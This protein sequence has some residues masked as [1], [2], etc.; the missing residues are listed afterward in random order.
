M[1]HQ[2]SRDICTCRFSPIHDRTEKRPLIKEIA[3]GAER[4]RQ[5]LVFVSY[6]F[7][8]PDELQ[9]YTAHFELRLPTD[10]EILQLINGVAVRWSA[11]NHAPP[12]VIPDAIKTMLI[13]NM[14][15]LSVQEV[16]RVL[17]KTLT[18]QGITRD[19]IDDVL[20]A[21]YELPS[22]KTAFSRTNRTLPGSPTSAACLI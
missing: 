5:I 22:I 8:I 21:K 2:N 20:K 18:A 3:Q 10:D 19:H 7:D 9:I 17:Q 1:E 6:K 15:G 14:R 16:E 12:M 4:Y 11:N 13:K